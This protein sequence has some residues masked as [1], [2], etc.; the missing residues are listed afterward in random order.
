MNAPS[1]SCQ[2][3]FDVRKIRR[4]VELMKEHD[5]TEI[6]LHQGEVRIQLRRA[7]ANVPP[8]LVQAPMAVAPAAAPSPARPVTSTRVGPR[9]ARSMARPARPR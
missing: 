3:I 1:P 8:M 5:L 9:S 4:L 7:S 6:D 2:D